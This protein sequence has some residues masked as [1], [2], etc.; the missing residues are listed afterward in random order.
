MLE[1]PL[2]FRV[3]VRNDFVQFC[4]SRRASIAFSVSSTA[5]PLMCSILCSYLS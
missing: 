3:K 1:N 5:V 2:R 4:F